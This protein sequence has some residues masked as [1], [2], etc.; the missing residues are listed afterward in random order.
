MKRLASSL[1]LIAAS[2][3]CTAS[4]LLAQQKRVSPHETISATVDDSRVMIVYGRPYTKDPKSGEERKVWGGIV[5]FG[6]VWRMGA[7]EATLLVNANP[8]AFG[9]TVVPPGA[10]ELF[11]LPMEDGSAKLIIN[12]RVG[13]WGAYTYDEKQDLARVDLKKEAAASPADQFTI[14]IDKG[15]KGSGTGTL[16]FTW[17]DAEYALPFTVKK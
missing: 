13:E 3:V 7:D 17:A 9:D 16:K 4:P 11:M 15:E 12:N 6:K 14:A 10:H 5:P 2:L 8:L 1:A